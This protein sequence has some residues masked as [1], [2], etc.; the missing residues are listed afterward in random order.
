M[1]SDSMKSCFCLITSAL[2]LC[3][4]ELCAQEPPPSQA[5]WIWYPEVGL[6]DQ[7]R[8]FRREFQLPE[9]PVGGTLNF[10]GDD[11]YTIWVNGRRIHRSVNFKC[12]PF[13]AEKYLKAGTN[14]IAA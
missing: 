8:F 10:S 3:A 13:E 1:G 7:L 4:A 6:K 11:V 9:K 12:P 5:K 2:L 14:V